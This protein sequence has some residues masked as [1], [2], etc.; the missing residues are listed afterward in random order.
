MQLNVRETAELMNVSEKTI[1]RWVKQ[2]RLPA[3]RLN[4]Q[5][6][7]HK[8]ELLAW[9]NSNRIN[10]SVDMFREP[11]TENV[12]K[13]GLA[14]AIKAGGIYYRI[15]GSDKKSVL[16][17]IVD[18]IPLPEEADKSFLFEVLVAR[19]SLGSTAIGN[20]IAIPH[21]RNPIVLHIEHPIISVC[22]LERPINFSALDGKPVHTLFTII[23][24]TTSAHLNLLSRLSFA[25]HQSN[26]AEVIAMQGLRDEIVESASAI[27]RLVAANS[28]NGCVEKAAS[29]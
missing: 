13:T 24:P 19:E 21:V 7:F 6:R 9:A 12:P 23:S 25:L 17:R 29:L 15:G 3:F 8:A 18:R 10:V 14:D 27:D 16:S 1:Y 11:E 20:G 22:F 4:A 2:R 28:G 26:F 5:Y